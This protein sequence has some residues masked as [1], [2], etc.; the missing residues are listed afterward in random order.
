[1]PLQDQ[2]L[3]CSTLLTAADWVPAMQGP[4]FDADVRRAEGTIYRWVTRLL[5]QR[6]PPAMSPLTPRGALPQAT[7]RTGE[8]TDLILASPAS[9]A[10]ELLGAPCSESILP[11]GLILQ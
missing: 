9:H 7:A 4:A 8:A 11:E 1:M 5:E 2:Q 3:E 10:L 6:T